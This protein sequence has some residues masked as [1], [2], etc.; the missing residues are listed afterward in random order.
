MREK[1]G[2][3]SAH[4]LTS[5]P[6][7]CSFSV[8]SVSE[9]TVHLDW[10]ARV[11]FFSERRKT[12]MQRFERQRDSLVDAALKALAKADEQVLLGCEVH[13]AEKKRRLYSMNSESRIQERSTPRRFSPQPI[14]ILPL[15]VL[16]F[17]SGQVRS[18]GRRESE[19]DAFSAERARYHEE[20][21]AMKAAQ[22][23]IIREQELANAKG[24]TALHVFPF[25]CIT[26]FV[27][28]CCLVI[29]LFDDILFLLLP[30]FLRFFFAWQ[31][32]KKLVVNV[33]VKQYKWRRSAK[34]RRRRLHSTANRRKSDS[35]SQKP[36]PP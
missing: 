33:N 21:E 25:H 8:F 14:L 7:S 22:Q 18:N 16:L 10:Y 34:R 32:R 11:R 19:M 2:H 9:L 6:L 28:F 27:S 36:Q 17:S 15:L 35:E 26:I 29:I 4:V 3:I 30:L 23:A 20:F 24:M 5:L 1:L 13:V 31:L 12:C